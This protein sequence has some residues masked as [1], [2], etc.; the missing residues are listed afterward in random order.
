[1]QRCDATNAVGKSV[2][3]VIHVT[4]NA[5]EPVGTA[6]GRLQKW[7]YRVATVKITFLG[8]LG[9][10]RRAFI[11]LTLNQPYVNTT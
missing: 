2:R 3:K 8:K 9:W 1:M 10:S 5:G 6:N 7:N 11:P 4:L